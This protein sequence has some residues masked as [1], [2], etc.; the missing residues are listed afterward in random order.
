[1]NSVPPPGPCSAA[2]GRNATSTG[3]LPALYGPQTC[4]RGP[5]SRTVLLI[6]SCDPRS[7]LSDRSREPV[8]YGA[9]AGGQET[10]SG[11]KQTCS[12]SGR[13]WAWA[14]AVPSH[15]A[16]TGGETVS[17]RLESTKHKPHACGDWPPPRSAPVRGSRRCHVQP[18]I[19]QLRRRPGLQP[20]DDAIGCVATPAVV[21]ICFCDGRQQGLREASSSI[22]LALA[23]FRN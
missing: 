2:L 12:R 15:R 10:L 13:G 3:A 8:T 23:G 9:N 22:S 21:A 19:A 4:P 16:P 7:A 17:S 14:A 1:M 18:L 5:T 11:V 20:A 6:A